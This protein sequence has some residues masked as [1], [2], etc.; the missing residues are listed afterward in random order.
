MRAQYVRIRA[1]YCAL[2]T[3]PTTNTAVYRGA[4]SSAI[5]CHAATCRQKAEQCEQKA[6]QR[7]EMNAPKSRSQTLLVKIA[8]GKQAREK[9]MSKNPKILIL[10]MEKFLI[11]F[12]FFAF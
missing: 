8:N 1:T 5:S 2:M 3:P 11:K 6:E 7:E 4:L 12:F 10:K 9:I